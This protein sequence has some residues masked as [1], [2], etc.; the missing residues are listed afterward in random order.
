MSNNQHLLLIRTYSWMCDKPRGIIFFLKLENKLTPMKTNMLNLLL[1]VTLVSFASCEGKKTEGA[2]NDKEVA[3][4]QNA[5]KTEDSDEKK[6]ADFAVE[7][8]DAGLYEVQVSTLAAKKASSPSVKKFAQMMVD[9]HGK[10]NSELKDLAGKKSLT[11][12]D[13]MCEK[14]QKKYYDLDQ[15]QANDFDKEYID[16][17]IQDHKDDIDKFERE[18]ENGN[19]SELKAWASAKLPTLRHHLEEAERIKEELKKS[20]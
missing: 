11:L 19:D 15:K 14:C 18:A 4:D 2:E 5:Q 17:M 20:K 7:V 6:D 13:V 16:L 8:A 1:F 12:P 3:A 9:D 10:S